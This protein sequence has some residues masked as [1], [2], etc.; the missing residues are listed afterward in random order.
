MVILSAYNCSRVDDCH[1]YG[2]LRIAKGGDI[3]DGF[4]E[5][6]INGKWGAVCG[7]NWDNK[8]AEV[9]CRQLGY[10]ATGTCG[11]LFF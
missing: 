9:A 4:L 3:E 8:D 10:Q 6:C 1:E 7:D 5:Y 11:L 2:K